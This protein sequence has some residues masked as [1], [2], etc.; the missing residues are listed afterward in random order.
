MAM[1]ALQWFRL[2]AIVLYVLA[3]VF[4][5]NRCSPPA[6][7]PS[8]PPAGPAR[9]PV[10]PTDPQPPTLP[11]QPELS[12]QARARLAKRD[13]QERERAARLSGYHQ[14]ESELKTLATIDLPTALADLATEAERYRNKRSDL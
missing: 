14:L 9:A 8:R 6:Y 7:S 5:V 2:A 4:V 13:R 12:E 11:R 3:I 1:A 10:P